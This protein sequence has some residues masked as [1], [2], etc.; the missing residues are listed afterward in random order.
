[1]ADNEL[2]SARV[3]R[4]AALVWAGYVLALAVMDT[5]IYRWQLF[6]P[7][8][9]YH[10]LNAAPALAFLALA[11]SPLPQKYPKLMTPLMIALATIAPIVI[12][13]LFGQR[14]PDAPLSNIEGTFL[15]QLPILMVGVILIAWHYPARV[16]LVCVGA[17]ALAEVILMNVRPPLAEQHTL[18]FYFSIGI[19]VIALSVVGVFINQLITWLKAEH[20]ALKAANDQLAHHASA[21][22]TLAVS[23]ERNRLARELHDTLAHTLSGLSVQLET[24]RAY[25][26][27][28]AQTS[29]KL[30]DQA[31]DTTRSGLDETRR[32]LKAL[33]ASPLEDLGLTLA[34]KQLAQSAA[35]RGQLALAFD[36]PDALPSLSPDVEQCVY[37]IA[38]EAIQNVATHAHAQNL[39]VRLAAQNKKIE[40][41]V[42]DD[43]VGADLTK[44]GKDGHFG[45]E[46]M[47]ERAKLAGGAL[48]IQS[49][50]GH[51]T[52]VAL[53]I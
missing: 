52:R 8:L 24:A 25:R 47:Q 11:Y 39:R 7:L 35:E 49:K 28:D 23:R 15:R 20:N 6:P 50:Q 13:Q 4:A 27:V 41:I 32:A 26:E 9:S 43:G 46:G 2:Q 19:Q 14:L 16:T 21:L 10:A 12:S 1:M 18:A 38:Q 5:F 51:G 44:P 29:N 53:V 34:V 45:V 37:R 42:Q 31:L 22:E 3:F 40:L 36:A 48:N 33:R 30:M 17:L